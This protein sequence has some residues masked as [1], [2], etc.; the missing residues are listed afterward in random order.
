MWDFIWGKIKSEDISIPEGHKNIVRKRIEASNLNPNRPLDWDKVKSE[1][2][3]IG[4]LELIL[5]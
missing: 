4:Y 2:K 1:I 3:K 5:F